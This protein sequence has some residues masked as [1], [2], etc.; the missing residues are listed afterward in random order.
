MDITYRVAIDENGHIRNIGGQDMAKDKFI[1]L[2]ADTFT[3]SRAGSG[4]KYLEQNKVYDT[5]GFDPAIVEE[6]VRAGAAK[7]ADGKKP[8]K[9]T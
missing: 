8:A 4:G 9:E 5:A 7:Y 1:W 2:A 6:W 3:R